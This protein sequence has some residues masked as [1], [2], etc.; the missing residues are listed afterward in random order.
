[1]TGSRA[2]VPSD[3]STP[4]KLEMK[5]VESVVAVTVIEE[6]RRPG[7]SAVAIGNV[8]AVTTRIAFLRAVNLGK[9]KVPMSRLVDVCDG[10]GYRDVWTHA[11]SGNAVFEATGS[12]SA[13]ERA[14][15]QA[16]E[17]AMGF[18]VTTFVR[19]ATELKRAVQLRPFK[20]AAGDTYF[21]TFLKNPPSAAT[22][23]SLESASNDF[24][25]LEVHG[26]DVHWRMRGKSTDTK[27]ASKTWSQVGEH[28]ST[29]RNV[30]LLEKLV[31]K[32]DG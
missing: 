16:L 1:V 15:E 31:A 11:N 22:A 29:S 7:L 10:L 5:S 20:L 6:L 12:R 24:D 25:T 18:E 9:R 4:L 28:G 8:H 27:L 30:N 21:I 17:A 23:R 14:M 2:I 13:I 3:F 19:S 32:L 26:R